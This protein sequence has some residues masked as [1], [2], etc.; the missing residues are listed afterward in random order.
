MQGR[1]APKPHSMQG[2]KYWRLPVLPLP[3]TL[4]LSPEDVQSP[5][6]EEALDGSFL[7][8]GEELDLL[9]EILDSLS[10][11]AK[12]MGSLRPSQS[13]DCCHR[14]DLDSCFSLVRSP[15]LLPQTPG[16][17]CQLRPSKV[18]HLACASSLPSLTY[19]EDRDGSPSMGNRQSPSPCPCLRTCRSCSTPRLWMPP[20][21]QRTPIP[22]CLPETTGTPSP[23]PSPSWLPQT[24]AAR[25]I[26]NSLLS[27][28][29]SSFVCPLPERQL[30]IPE[31]WTAPALD[32]PQHPPNPAPQKALNFQAPT[33]SLPA[34]PSLWTF[35]WTPVLQSTPKLSLP[36]S[37]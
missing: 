30:K 13:L 3:R 18:Q 24:P 14:G 23:H 37:R 26:P 15:L 9:S 28:N 21:P 7:G 25:G 31:P 27:W 20:A 16:A 6:A 17:T 32:S 1:W 8:S 5:W 33:R 11:G 12:S 2:N 34:P 35:P 4:S 19:R 10:V 29:P 36:R 22:S